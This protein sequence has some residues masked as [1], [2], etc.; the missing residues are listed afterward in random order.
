MIVLHVRCQTDNYMDWL[1]KFLKYVRVFENRFAGG[2]N[3]NI[4]WMCMAFNDIDIRIFR[5]YKLGCQCGNDEHCL[6][7]SSSDSI[8]TSAGIYHFGWVKDW[9]AGY[10]KC[11]KIFLHF[12]WCCSFFYFYLHSYLIYILWID[13]G[14]IHSD[15]W[16]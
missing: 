5:S 12:C 16:C 15:W 10:F 7:V 13:C 3:A 9:Q 14:I 4:G 1:A 11:E 2:N 6:N 8:W